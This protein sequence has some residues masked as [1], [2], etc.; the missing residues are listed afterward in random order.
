MLC[1]PV[2]SRKFQT[3]ASNGCND[4]LMMF[5][6]LDDI[7]ILNKSSV[8]NRCNINGISKSKSVNLLKKLI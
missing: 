1:L 4:L 2:K 3:Y 6:N 5:I 7:A 8:D